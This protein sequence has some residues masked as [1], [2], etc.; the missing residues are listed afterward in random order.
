MLIPQ[1]DA[2]KLVKLKAGD[3]F[4]RARL[5]ESTKAIGDRLG[6]DGYAFA[7]VNAVPDLDKDKRKVAFTFFID[8]GRRVYIRRIN[9]AGNTRTRDEV[10]RREMRQLEG[11][12]F[13]A[14]SITKSKQRVDRLG[15]FTEVNVETP[16]VPGTTDQVDLNLSVVEKPTG[17][18]LLGAGFG[19]TEGVIPAP[20]CRSK[21][22][23]ARVIFSVSAVNTQQVHH[24]LLSSPLPS[25]TG[26]CRR[27]RQP[28]I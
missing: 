26:W 15:Y 25:P 11:G 9:V 24:G 22:C 4:S 13:S 7:N 20:A 21:M 3:I 17:N 2:L 1:A 27:R 14:D 12:W 28:R 5:T 19:S 10:I 8:P 16:S 23:L 6:N 18:I